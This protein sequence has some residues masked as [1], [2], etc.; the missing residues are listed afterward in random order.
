[1][2]R[3]LARLEPDFPHITQELVDFEPKD[4]TKETMLQ[5]CDL[6]GNF[7]QAHLHIQAGETRAIFALKNTAIDQVVNFSGTDVQTNGKFK[8]D[9]KSLTC[10]DPSFHASFSI[11]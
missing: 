4:D 9:G 3:A 1:M 10:L 8:L 7:Y 11:C 6:I 5:V 2:G